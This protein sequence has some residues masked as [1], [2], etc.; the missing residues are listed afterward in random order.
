MHKLSIATLIVASLAF[1]GLAFAQG[2]SVNAGATTSTS[3]GVNAAG[4]SVNADATTSTSADVAA[5]AS[6]NADT[7][8][9]SANASSADASSAASSASGESAT[10]GTVTSGNV[11][12][13]AIDAAALAAITSVTVFSTTD[14][15]GLA[16]LNTLDA[17]AGGTLSGNAMVAKAI[18]DAG[19]TTNDIAGYIVDGTSL[20][21][22]IKK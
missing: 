13:G 14:C 8:N 20:T 19:Y 15:S 12:T 9:S 17:G 5:S 11:A 4:V 21:V 3:A 6:T 16:G 2:V 10:C 1:S 7:A 22:Y 18:T